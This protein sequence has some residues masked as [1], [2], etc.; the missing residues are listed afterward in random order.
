[1]ALEQ[2]QVQ[3]RV[4]ISLCIARG[5]MAWYAQVR[6]TWL[7]PHGIEEATRLASEAHMCYQGTL[8]IGTNS[9]TR[10]ASVLCVRQKG[11]RSQRTS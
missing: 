10:L 7:C 8:G 5:H 2:A 11:G 3:H 6:S 1:M 4:G 9:A